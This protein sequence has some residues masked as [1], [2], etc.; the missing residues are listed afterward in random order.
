MLDIH[1][2]H[3]QSQSIASAF[4]IANPPFEAVALQRIAATRIR[5]L[6]SFEAVFGRMRTSTSPSQ[7]A[8]LIGLLGPQLTARCC[9]R[10]AR[11]T[12]SIRLFFFFFFSPFLL[13]LPSCL[14]CGLSV[15]F[16]LLLGCFCFRPL[17]WPEIR[18]AVRK[19]TVCSRM[20]A[21]LGMGKWQA[22]ARVRD[23]AVA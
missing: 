6:A 1:R 7:A 8:P 19:S 13:A 3:S 9:A 14:S 5:H 4:A 16:D 18:F 12:A 2:W 17:V 21:W 22:S 23:E 20:I 10:L 11:C 15:S